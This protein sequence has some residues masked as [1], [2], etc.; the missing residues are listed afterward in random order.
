M[1]EWSLLVRVGDRLSDV[2]RSLL[3][4]IWNLGLRLILKHILKTFW[5]DLIRNNKYTFT[6]LGIKKLMISPVF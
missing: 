2:V 5:W 1:S 6:V 3:L 4:G